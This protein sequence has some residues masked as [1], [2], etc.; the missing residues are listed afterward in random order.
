MTTPFQQIL[1]KRSQLLHHQAIWQE[2]VDHLRRFIDTD[3]APAKQGI[4]TEGGGM[5][6]PQSAIGEV[7]GEIEQGPITKIQDEISR[8][9]NSE[10]A[11]N[12]RPKDESR[13]EGKAKGRKISGLPSSRGG[14]KKA[15]GNSRTT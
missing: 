13:K 7:V 11:D 5:V 15:A 3:A 8:I 1:I 14:S 4:R 12:V 2:V 10:V 6:V 9:D